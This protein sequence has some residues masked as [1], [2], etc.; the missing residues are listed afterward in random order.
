MSDAV[1]DIDAAITS[2]GSSMPRSL[3]TRL[4]PY[5]NNYTAIAIILIALAVVLRVIFTALV[6][7]EVNSDEGAM[8]LEAMHIA[9]KGEHPIF[10]YGQD[11]MGVLEAYVAAF[12]FRLFGVSVF[13]PR[14]HGAR[15]LHGRGSAVEAVANASYAGARLGHRKERS[16]NYSIFSPH[17]TFERNHH[18]GTL[19]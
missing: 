11:Y 14:S 10:L 6:V 7:P 8:G 4:K 12:F 9:F 2:R 13:S 1:K 5:I 17:D 15:G 3:A 16:R 19:C 18:A